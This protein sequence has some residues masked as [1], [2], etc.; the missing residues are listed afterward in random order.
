MAINM[1]IS[2]DLRQTMQT[3]LTPEQI[4]VI[5]M[6]ECPNIEL[7][8]RIQKELMENPV[9]EIG[10]DEPEEK[11]QEENDYSQDDDLED[12]YGDKEDRGEDP[13]Q[14]E[15]FD[16]NTY[17]SDDDP[18]DEPDYKL[19]QN[20]ASADTD[21]EQMPIAQGQDFHEYLEEQVGQMSLSEEEQKI[22]RYVIGNID[23]RGYLTRSVDQMV[24]DLAF[25]GVAEVSFEEMSKIVDIIRHL[26][27]VGTGAYDLKDCLLMQ[28]TRQEQT[29]AVKLAIQLVE[30]NLEDLEK[31]HFDRLRKRYNLT[32]EAFEQ[33]HEVIT[34]CRPH[35]STSFSNDIYENR[36]N[37]ITPDFRVE[38]I[39]GEIF[40]S[41]T[42]DH[43][44][45][46]RLSR[47]YQNMLAQLQKDKHTKAEKEAV[48]FLKEKFESGRNFIDAIRQRNETLLN[49]MRAIAF[50]QK[51]YFLMGDDCYLKPMILED[52][53]KITGTDPSTISRVSNSKYVQTDFG[54]IP[55]KHFFSESLKNMEG[56]DISTKEIK[57]Q[58][59]LIVDQEDKMHPYTDDQLVEKLK[60][61]G[62]NIARRT[63]AKYR[64]QM[65][66]PITG[67]RK[68]LK[69]S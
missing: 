51:D 22:A 67:Q 28:L 41:L 16:Y 57:K 7:E 4:Q 17:V 6:I 5:K 20:N 11:Q 35:P 59:R 46:I 15:D 49:T 39:D 23:N 36:R 32:K 10:E 18:Y 58:L 42:D 40:V 43:V 38:V 45:P 68:R 54:I 14:N 27:P 21:Y 65:N 13:L 25:S 19:K 56:E 63:I 66:I 34:N 64:V 61:L 37:H 24:D 60:E 8:E 2:T 48:R 53:A 31:H 47:D 29:P 50:F 12:I 62:Y 26:D 52:I 30:R 44:S 55:L 69:N 1:N 3:R 33:A 9:L